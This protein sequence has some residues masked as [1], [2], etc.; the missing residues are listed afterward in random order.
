M[1]TIE[2]VRSALEAV[3][4]LP[5]ASGGLGIASADVAWKGIKFDPTTRTTRWYRPTFIPGTPRAAAIGT[6]AA[7]RYVFIFQIDIFDPV[8]TKGEGFT[9]TEAQRLM[10]AFKRGTAFSRNGQVTT[11]EKSYRQTTDDSD[12]KWVKIAVVIEG[13]ADVPN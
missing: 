6:S 3:L 5:I 12:P 11:C 7:N 1:S 8:S 10:A 2:D 4:T 13:W 9:A